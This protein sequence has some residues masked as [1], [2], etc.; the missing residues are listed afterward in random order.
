MST[1][2]HKKKK[3]RKIVLIDGS[4]FVVCTCT[5]LPLAAVR[6]LNRYCLDF[7]GFSISWWLK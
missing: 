5:F 6:I 4:T 1:S 3:E 7:P 2:H